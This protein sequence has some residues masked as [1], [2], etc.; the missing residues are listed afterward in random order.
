M[1]QH[2]T[3]T[4]ERLGFRR[5]DPPTPDGALLVCAWLRVETLVPRHWVVM[6]VIEAEAHAERLQ[7]AGGDVPDLDAAVPGLAIAWAAI[8]AALDGRRPGAPLP[9]W[10]AGLDEVQEP[11]YYLTHEQFDHLERAVT[12]GAPLREVI[13]AMLPQLQARPWHLTDNGTVCLGAGQP[14]EA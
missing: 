5:P 2:A 6:P 8:H 9:E 12:G 13:E 7:R 3:A 14:V 1:P 11:G 4:L 10:V